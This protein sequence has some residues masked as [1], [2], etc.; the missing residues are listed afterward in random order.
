MVPYV[1]ISSQYLE[2]KDE[3]LSVIDRTLAE[4]Q[5]IL[6][7][8]VEKFEKSFAALSGTRFAISVANG[9]DALILVLKAMGIGAGDEVI[10]C[11]NS[12]VSSAS[13]IALLGAKPVFVDVLEDQSMDPSLLEGTI[14][15]KTKAIIPVHLTGKV[16]DMN[17]I[18]AIASKRGIPVVEDS[19]QAVG[20]KYF[21]KAAGALGNAGCFSLHPLK[22]LN[23]CGDA[24][25]ITTND[26]KLAVD[27]KLL[28]HHG[29]IDRN[30]VIRWGY[31]SRLDTMQAAILNFR[32]KTL[33]DTTEKRRLHAGWY[34]DELSSLVYCPTDRPECFDVYHTFV[35]QA[36]KRNELKEF[37][38][39]R[40][41]FTAIHYP[42]PIH[43]QPAAAALGYKRGSFP[44]VEKQ[45]ERIL[46]L[47]IHQN[48]TQNQIHKVTEAIKEFY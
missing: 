3:I 24:G 30:T 11:P 7:N 32:M 2:F 42:I 40:E 26:D 44:V 39:K 14:T 46:S 31:N 43:F 16:A 48:L 34:R 1:D 35:I 28:R 6:G 37:L 22:N 12:W 36:E 15:S 45:S 9:T 19:A 17:P 27:L 33:N 18:L 13:C 4:G 41:I 20:A 25:I 8:E 47:P 5:Y 38:Q 23:A 29:L 10:T 21:G